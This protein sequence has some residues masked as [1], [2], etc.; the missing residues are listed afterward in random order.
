MVEVIVSSLASEQPPALRGAALR[1]AHA[2]RNI[3][4]G[5]YMPTHLFPKFSAA[6]HSTLTESDSPRQH[7]FYLQILYSCAKSETWRA[8]ILGH[9]HHS[10]HLHIAN[11][12][13]YPN[14]DPLLSEHLAL[15]IIANLQ[16]MQG[17]SDRPLDLPDAHSCRML[18]PKA[19]HSLVVR[20]TGYLKE[21]IE[22]LSAFTR[23]RLDERMILGTDSELIPSIRQTL[24]QLR[25]SGSD[26]RLISAVDQLLQYITNPQ[27][28]NS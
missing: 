7:L 10:S 3:I 21:T 26:I 25:L 13:P 28:S 24:G 18:V 11:A 27:D 12:F 4:F 17:L 8:H 23:D 15:Y 14:I 20:P 22:H 1:A 5:S 19:W 16:V 9:G 2:C 6:L